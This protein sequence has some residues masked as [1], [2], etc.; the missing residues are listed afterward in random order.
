MQPDRMGGLLLYVC[1]FLIGTLLLAFVVLPA[2]LA[3]IA[4]VS[5]REILRE[6]Q[7][8]FVLALVTTLSVVALPFVQKAADG[9]ADRA[10]CPQ[11]EERADII[12]A[13][14]SLSYVLAHSAIISSIC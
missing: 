1:L 2:V 6:L 5:H 7:P 10:G 9:I 11:G 3:T 8:A 14:L 13:S 4:P 12:Q